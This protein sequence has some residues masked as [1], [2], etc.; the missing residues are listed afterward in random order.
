MTESQL[1]FVPW[2]LDHA[3]ALLLTAIL[4]VALISVRRQLRAIDDRWLRRGLAILLLG[5]ELLSWPIGCSQG[6]VRVPLQLCDVTL[7]LAT[8]ALLLGEGRRVNELAYFWG[9]AGSVQALLTPD[10]AQPFPSYWWLK[11]F[12]S[13]IGIV[14]AT[15]YLALTGRV[16]PT[17]RSVWAAF[18][19]GNVYVLC[20]GLLNWRFSL[21]LGYL[22][23]KPTHP[24]L[25]DYFGPW[26][27]YIL[28]M[29]VIAF[30]S[31]LLL[32]LP[33]ALFPRVAR[34]A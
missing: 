4:V 13:H 3:A 25:L 10:L 29:E 12:V 15:T 19:W 21:N 23:E 30:V 26:P 16:Q 14:V 7:V 18:G 31:F 1:R 32:G 17:L 8:W 9:L 22:A 24:S 33:F 11:F 6:F 27:V 5:N 28:A 34:R 20:A 2:G